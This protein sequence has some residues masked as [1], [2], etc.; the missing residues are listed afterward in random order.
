MWQDGHT[1]EMANFDG[2]GNAVTLNNI[3]LS[4]LTLEH[5]SHAVLI[6]K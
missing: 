4:T 6:L 3:R 5:N 2:L 1:R